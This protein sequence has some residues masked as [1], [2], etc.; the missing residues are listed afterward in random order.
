MKIVF[1]HGRSQQKKDPQA[2][3][4]SWER[5]L[6]KGFDTYGEPYTEA[7]DIAFPY[8]GDLLF[9]ATYEKS[10][11]DFQV[12][13]DK[14]AEAVAPGGEEE[15]FMREVIFSIATQEGISAGQIAY[16][17][18]GDLAER[19]VQNWRSVLAA[20]RLLDQLPGVGATSIE[21]ATRDV[22]YYLTKKS[23]RDKVNLIVDADIPK[24]EPCIIVAHS[25]GTLVAYNLLMN[26]K[27]RSNI[28][29]LVTIGSPLGIKAIY[30]RLPSNGNARKAPGDVSQW[31]NL[32][33]SRDVVALYDIPQAAYDG[34][35]VVQ[36]NSKAVN[37]SDNR[38]GIGDYLEDK[39]V[40]SLLRNLLV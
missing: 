26:G 32:R 31:L 17:A 20:L 29:A 9:D 25:L 16:E 35:P 23:I 19:G 5:A 39:T 1:I 7:L 24:D 36:N 15:E 2:L 27:P 38:H 37:E 6:L 3:K 8:Y 34:T 12:L 22:W 33:D 4:D 11:H 14:G 13:A 28:K 30:S 21:L 40:A 18:N 10:Q